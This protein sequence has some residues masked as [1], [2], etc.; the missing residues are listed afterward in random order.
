M[1]A[2]FISTSEDNIKSYNILINVLLVWPDY[3][4]SHALNVL[5]LIYVK[6]REPNYN[7]NF[8]NNFITLEIP[9]SETIH[10]KISFKIYLQNINM[11][12][13]NQKRSLTHILLPIILT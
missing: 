13:L 2:S 5:L 4:L 1:I 8:G 11:Q 9:I 7:F 3:A 10:N 6:Q 12:Q